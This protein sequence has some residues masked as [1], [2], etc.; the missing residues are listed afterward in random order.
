MERDFAEGAGETCEQT[1]SKNY[2][3][4]SHLNKLSNS[5]ALSWNQFKNF[6]VVNSVIRGG[7]MLN[8]GITKYKAR[9]NCDVISFRSEMG[10]DGPTDGPTDQRTNI[11]S[12]RGTTSRLK[13]IL[14]IT[15]SNL[16]RQIP[17]AADRPAG[18]WPPKG[19]IFMTHSCPLVTI[20]LASP[21]IWNLPK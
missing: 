8:K 11:V 16:N 6:I 1:V 15:N 17:R 10:T 18:D 9:R 4:V 13:R 2:H 5:M 12:Y 3:T 14:L 19:R 7:T 21:W 20:H